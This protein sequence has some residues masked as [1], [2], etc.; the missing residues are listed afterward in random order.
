MNIEIVSGSPRKE[1]I[2]YRQAVYLQKHLTAKTQHNIGLIDVREWNL[3][4]LQDQVFSSVDNTPEQ[5]KPL[6]SRMFSAHAFIMVTP[7]YNGS[8]TPALK[9]M[10][11]YFPKQMHKPFGIVTASSGNLGGIRASQQLQLLICA[12]FGVPSPYMLVTPQVDKKFDTN[13]NLLEESF[14]HSINTFV[15]EFLWLAEKLHP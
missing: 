9:G 4:V 3:P 10:F 14:Q 13:G 15:H 8:Y 7:E 6:A 5:Y 2:T 11:D 12:L 1:S